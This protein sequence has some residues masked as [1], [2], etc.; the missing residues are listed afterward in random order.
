[1]SFKVYIGTQLVG[2]VNARTIDGALKKAIKKF[3]SNARIEP[4]KVDFSQVK[5]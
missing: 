4:L 2:Y 1:M 3:G 5:I